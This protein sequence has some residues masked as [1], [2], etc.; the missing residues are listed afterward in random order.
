MGKR[1]DR[2][3]ED[4]GTLLKSFDPLIHGTSSVAERSY[5]ELLKSL[6][7]QAEQAFIELGKEVLTAFIARAWCLHSVS[8]SS[9]N[10]KHYSF[11]LLLLCAS[12]RTRSPGNAITAITN[13]RAA[14]APHLQSVGQEN[15]RQSA[16]HC[17]QSP[18]GSRGHGKLAQA[19]MLFGFAKPNLYVYARIT[20]RRPNSQRS[21]SSSAR[22][23][24]SE[25]T[26]LP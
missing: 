13:S 8:S 3:K 10:A 20:A 16:R 4:L 1:F 2:S 12:C 19:P 14:G 7:L 9:S 5:L 15:G 21:P 6:A 18:A 17:G 11:V 26:T 22:T 23:R 24:S 25:C